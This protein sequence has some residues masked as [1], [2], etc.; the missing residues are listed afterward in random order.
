LYRKE[1]TIEYPDRE[2]FSEEFVAFAMLLSFEKF[3]HASRHSDPAGKNVTFKA[4][5]KFLRSTGL[6]AGSLITIRGEGQVYAGSGPL[7]QN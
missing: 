3:G 1:L 6:E 7:R 2:E 4:T 5:P